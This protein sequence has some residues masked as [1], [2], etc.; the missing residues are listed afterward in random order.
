MKIVVTEFPKSGGNWLC[1]LIG[2][3]LD[4]PKRDIYD[5]TFRPPHIGRHPWY[6]NG[7]DIPENVV[8]KSHEPPDSPLFS[9]EDHV[10]IHLVRDGR[11]VVVSKFFYEKNFCIDNGILT[12]FDYEFDDYV[13]RTAK[14]WAAYVVAWLD[15]SSVPLVRYEDLL[16]D[17]ALCLERALTAIGCAASR[18]CIA[19]AVKE[20]TLSKM[21]QRFNVTFKRNT[22]FRKGVAGDYRN[23]FRP[24]NYRDFNLVAADAMA[25]LGYKIL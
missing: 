16:S 21:R 20:N 12:N 23:Y 7:L 5:V 11:D 15:N 6:R 1:S 4:I 9:G 18:D 19:F 14:E 17:P 8:I 3:S 25:L 22:F 10:F 24:E 13:V 2:D